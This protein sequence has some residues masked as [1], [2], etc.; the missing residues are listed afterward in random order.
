MT[1]TLA[2]A[3]IPALLVGCLEKKPRN[4]IS[5]DLPGNTRRMPAEWEP[6]EA[7]WLQWPAEW[8]GRQVAD[9]FVSII[10]VVAEYEDVHLLVPDRYEHDRA[11][12][13]LSHV[14]RLT[15]HTVPTNSSWMRDNG[16]RYVEVDGELVIQNWEFDGW[17]GEWGPASLYVDD[18]V[19]PDV[20]AELLDLPTEYIPVI[21][22]RGDLEVNG[23]DTAMVNWSVVSHRNPGHSRKALTEAFQEALGVDSVIWAEGFDPMDGTR[24]HIDGMARFVAEDTILVGKDGSQLMEDVADQIRSQRPDLEVLRLE[25]PDAALFMN[26]LVGNGFV[27]VATSGY[28]SEDAVAE[29]V[30]GDLFAG[31]EVRFANVDALWRNGGGIHCVTNDQPVAPE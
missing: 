14:D 28:A 30:L 3:C 6:Q 20:V 16:P 25:S 19:V 11:S 10:E 24:G 12:G 9:S 8:E 22:E 29:E 18:N 31:R 13:A 5:M 27:L 7:I 4:D 1:R 17:G 26:F 2:L 15:I 23:S 21:H